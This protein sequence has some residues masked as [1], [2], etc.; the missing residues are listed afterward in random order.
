MGGHKTESAISGLEFH[1]QLQSRCDEGVLEDY[2]MIDGRQL[3]RFVIHRDL[4][5]Y[6]LL[7]DQRPHDGKA[8]SQDISQSRPETV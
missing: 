3:H 1:I 2:Q 7:H 4:H 8:R 6:R 5:P